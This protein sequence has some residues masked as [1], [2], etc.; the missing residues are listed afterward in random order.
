MRL[1]TDSPW[2]A[3]AKR[4]V[5]L[6]AR[7]D[8]RTTAPRGGLGWHPPYLVMIGD[9][10]FEPAQLGDAWRIRGHVEMIERADGSGSFPRATQHWADEHRWP[11]VG[12]SLTC[13]NER[14]PEGGHRWTHA[15]DCDGDYG[16]ACKLGAGRLSC[17]D[18]T[19]SAEAGDL[20]AS[21]SLWVNWDLC[22]WHGFLQ[23]GVMTSV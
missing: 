8:P 23:S 16:R 2:D 11:V 19:G 15:S 4:S 13:P 21:P 17:W 3:F 5:L 7:P 14:C 18:W 20:T 1:R 10:A 22:G 6:G 12:Y 9:D